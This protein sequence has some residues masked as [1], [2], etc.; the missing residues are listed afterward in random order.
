[1]GKKS[2]VTI[3]ACVLFLLATVYAAFWG[4]LAPAD[5]RARELREID[6]RAA[7]ETWV[8]NMTRD[9]R[10]DAV[11]ERMDPYVIGGETV[12]YI[13][14]IRGG[15]FC[16]CALDEL[17][18][19]VYFYAPRGSFDAANGPLMCILTQMADRAR[20]V[21]TWIREDDPIL[22]DMRAV[23]S[24]RAAAW[25]DLI[26][27]RVPRM[28]RESAEAAAIPT[29]MSFDLGCTWHQG[30]PYNDQCPSLPPGSDTHCVT[31]CPA[32]A[33]AQIMF[34]WKWPTTGTGSH[35][36]YREY[37]MRPDGEWD[38]IPLTSDP[39]LVGDAGWSWDGRLRWRNVVGS[40][41]M[42]EISGY[43]D[44]SILAT[45]EDTN[46]VNN[47][48]PA[49]KAAVDTLYAHMP[50]YST[51]HYVNFATATYNWSIIQ[52]VHDDPPDAGDAEVAKLNYHVGVAI[53]S[54]YGIRGTGSSCPETSAN[55]PIYLRYDP[56]AITSAANVTTM[57][58]EIT[59]LR[60]LS[61]GGCG[62]AWVVHGYDSSTDPDRLFLMNF[63]W[64]GAQDG[65]YVADTRC[66]MAGME[67]A[68]RLAPAGVVKFVGAA[69]NGDGT[70]A[71]PYRNIEQAIANASDGTT[72]IFKAGSDNT[73]VAAELTIDRPFTLK[74]KDVIIRKQ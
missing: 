13:A 40:G 44:W 37:R 14:Q 10:P 41:G 4:A 31:G 34:Y 39:Q 28:A 69:L 35:G 22:L 30:H 49:Y 55:V 27:G 42:L 53:N 52:G 43:W 54:I 20:M 64:G 50:V 46:Y 51:Y 3:R 45:A 59:W 7:A 72:L 71:T 18:L 60:P 25:T 57:T 12:A 5:L 48:S 1:M 36:I 63:G 73:Y 23:A 2:N 19:P 58:G 70:P 32:T 15:G 8:R 66:P 33:M 24:E 9:A 68:V 62:H 21:R 26:G 6:V 17:L 38:S 61:I 65:W 11:I 74:G 29:S 47:F 56:D 16:L 67:H